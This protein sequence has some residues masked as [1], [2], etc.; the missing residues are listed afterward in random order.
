MD[1]NA[2]RRVL[3]RAANAPLSNA[4]GSADDLY[5]P[6]NGRRSSRCV[7]RR[8]MDRTAV[9][10]SPAPLTV[11][12]ILRATP[13]G[14]VH[15]LPPFAMGRDSLAAL[16]QTVLPKLVRGSVVLPARPRYR[17]SASINAIGGYLFEL[18]PRHGAGLVVARIGMGG[19]DHGASLVWAA[20]GRKQHMAEP[21]R[22][23]VVDVLDATGMSLLNA[24]EASLLGRWVPLLASDLAWAATPPSASLSHPARNAHDDHPWEVRV[25][26]EFGSLTRDLDGNDAAGELL[27]R[28]PASPR[29]ANSVELRIAGPRPL[30]PTAGRR[31]GKQ[32]PRHA[33][34]R[35]Q[36]GDGPGRRVRERRCRQR[37]RPGFGCSGRGRCWRRRNASR[38]SD[39]AEC[40]RRGTAA[41]G[42]GRRGHAGGAGERKHAFAHPPCLPRYRERAP[43]RNWGK[44]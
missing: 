42:F 16:R 31:G 28:P 33:P 21:Q 37:T 39:A 32:S 36:S 25:T 4:R 2:A 14:R 11:Q 19:R 40:P 41:G 34:P 26:R 5:V 35:R 18:R 7:T 23:W 43:A 30:R 3:E 20:C 44:P 13:T 27:I 6:I 1:F 17:L 10:E 29:P 9:P 38:S 8:V 24:D 22:P 15:D 12:R